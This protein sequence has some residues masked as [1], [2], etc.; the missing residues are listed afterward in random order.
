MKCQTNEN[1]VRKISDKKKISDL[2]LK[3]FTDAILSEKASN[4]TNS[5]FVNVQKNSFSIPNPASQVV[6]SSMATGQAKFFDQ[7]ALK[8]TE[9]MKTKKQNK[10]A[11]TIKFLRK[12]LTD[13]KRSQ[14]KKIQKK[15]KRVKTYLREQKI[16]ISK[17][18]NE[19]IFD[20][21]E[22]KSKI[23]QTE[24]NKQKKKK[25]MKK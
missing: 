11:I 6:N 3:M 19:E 24:S 1:P 22:K 12:F 25:K 18:K 10:I 16:K 5:L 4:Q 15:I 2:I 23:K 13:S 14:P 7:T 8:T 9:E 20:E 17:K 21:I